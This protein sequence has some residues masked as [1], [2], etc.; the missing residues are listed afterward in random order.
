MTPDR[1]HSSP[2]RV[3]GKIHQ[4]ITV[5][6]RKFLCSQTPPMEM[7]PEIEAFILGRRVDLGGFAIE[8][9]K[10]LP[11]KMRP[12]VFQGVA[13]VIQGLGDEPTPEEWDRFDR[14]LWQPAWR[15]FKMLDARHREEVPDVETAHQLIVD[16]AG[17]LDVLLALIRK[18]SRD[19]DLK[20]SVGR[21][22][23]HQA[24]SPTTADLSSPAGPASMATSQ[25]K[26]SRRSKS[27]KCP[28]T[29]PAS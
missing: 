7:I 22:G 16:D 13:A 15:L 10:R 20:N 3:A 29:P 2:A 9:A 8:T 19:D 1:S 4:Y 25:S 21:Q 11:E 5:A 26:A 14:S 28:S 23:D 17:D 24:S 12:A 18:I 27:T 6:G